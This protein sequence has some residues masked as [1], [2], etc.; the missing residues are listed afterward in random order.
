MARVRHPTIAD[1]FAEL[2]N[3]KIVECA[4][5]HPKQRVYGLYDQNTGVIA[6]NRYP[7]DL[8][9]TLTHESLHRRYPKWGEKRIAR[10]TRYLMR[11]MS[12][13]DVKNI[14]RSYRRRACRLRRTVRLNET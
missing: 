13:D 2:A 7:A 3:G 4:I 1:V 10:E 8:A 6:V 5:T 9:D 11:R 12:D 14:C